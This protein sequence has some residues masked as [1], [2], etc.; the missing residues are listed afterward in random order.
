MSVPLTR[1]GLNPITEI[2]ALLTLYEVLR[3]RR[4]DLIHGFTIKAA[5]YGALAAILAGTERRILSI[6]GLGHVFTTP[7]TRAALVGRA[8]GSLLRVACSGHGTRV[9]I[10]NPDDLAFFTRRRW[11]KSDCLRLILGS[12]VDCA[13]FVPAVRGSGS[14][15]QPFRALFASRLLWSKGLD[16]FIAA[17]G[18]FRRLGI[19]SE[20]L[21][22]GTPDAGN[23]A[24]AKIRDIQSWCD[25]GVVK[26][27]GKVDDMPALFRSVDVFVLPTRYGEGVPRSLLEA[28]ACGLPLI[29]TDAPGCREVVC[30]G[31]EGII[32]GP[33]AVC[34]LVSALRL[35]AQD[36][37]LRTRMG[38]A[39]RKKALSTF[40][41]TSVLLQTS[42]VYSELLPIRRGAAGRDRNACN[43]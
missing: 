8:V 37:R 26:W 27:L 11:V 3:E 23:P 16:D 18:Q 5:V 41:E 21:I 30:D 13:K 28:A 17:A 7:G 25:R 35:L 31:V 40:E 42:Q 39:A 1:L 43:H 20:F 15:S 22:A 36:E 38:A 34:E 6:N 14:P 4:I 33:N 29:T 24:S 32:V 10:Q 19:V 12:G 2:S 9:I